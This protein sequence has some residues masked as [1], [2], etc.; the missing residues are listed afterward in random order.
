ME[1]KLFSV[2]DKICVITGGM[3]RWGPVCEG[4]PE[5]RRE[6]SRIWQTCGRGQSTEG[7]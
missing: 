3:G 6:G 2:R 4:V 7:V 1:D 5:P